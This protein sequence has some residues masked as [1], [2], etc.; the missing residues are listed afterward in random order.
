MHANHKIDNPDWQYS[1]GSNIMAA[2]S[3]IPDKAHPMIEK[4]LVSKHKE[5]TVNPLLGKRSHSDAFGKAKESEDN[6]NDKE[7]IN[8]T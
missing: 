4:W 2:N 8:Y 6:A 1:L 3:S 5:E 7:W